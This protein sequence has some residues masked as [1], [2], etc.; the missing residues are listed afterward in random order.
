MQD[1]ATLADLLNAELDQQAEVWTGLLGQMGQA[2][3]VLAL[4][5]VGQSESKAEGGAA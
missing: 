2:V 3:R 1:W 5:G 4:P